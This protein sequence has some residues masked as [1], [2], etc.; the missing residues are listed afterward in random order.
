MHKELNESHLF[1][2][3]CLL[4][5]LLEQKRQRHLLGVL[6]TKVT[7]LTQILGE[8]KTNLDEASQ[9]LT[10]KIDSLSAELEATQNL[11]P[12]AEELLNSIRGTSQALAAIVPN[13][14]APE[15]TEPAPEPAIDPET[16]LPVEPAAEN[17][18][19]ATL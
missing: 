1:Q 9:E 15:P 4:E 11:S 12:E 5:M 7:E 8:V 16:G 17:T 6:M 10:A 13:P 14:P 18:D 3:T 19:Q 2:E